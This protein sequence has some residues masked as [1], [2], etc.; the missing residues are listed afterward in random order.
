MYKILIINA[1]FNLKGGKENMQKE[2]VEEVL[3]TTIR[4]AQFLFK[5]IKAN[6]YHLFSVT[7]K[8]I[9]TYY[10]LCSLKTGL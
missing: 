2:N 6:K 7:N 4:I 9:Q 1:I 8:L 5:L 10:V 3:K